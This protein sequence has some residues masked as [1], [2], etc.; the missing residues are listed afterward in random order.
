MSMIRGRRD[1]GLRVSCSDVL[2][3]QRSRL[4]KVELS[5]EKIADQSSVGMRIS[6]ESG[7]RN[8]NRFWNWSIKRWTACSGIEAFGLNTITAD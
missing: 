6:K 3:S 2:V 4:C 8:R 7:L 1:H 5:S